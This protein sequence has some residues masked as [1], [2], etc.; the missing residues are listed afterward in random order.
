MKVK[1]TTLGLP[2]VRRRLKWLQNLPEKEFLDA[3]LEEATGVLELAKA[4]APVR[5]G[6][7]KRSGRVKKAGTRFEISFTAPYAGKVHE[8]PSSRGYKFLQ[9]AFFTRGSLTARNV[10]A[11]L[12]AR[13]KARMRG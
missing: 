1:I 6:R 10:A 13:I 8:N 9:N 7:L 4:N 5:T 12:R 11:K 2:K 3:M